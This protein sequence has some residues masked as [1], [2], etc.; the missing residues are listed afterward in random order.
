[1][2][3]MKITNDRFEAAAVKL[4]SKSSNDPVTERTVRMFVDGCR[5]QCTGSFDW[6]YSPPLRFSPLECIT[7][8][9]TS[10]DLAFSRSDTGSGISCKRT[11]ASRLCC[12]DR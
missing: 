9:L 6:R 5:Y 12:R 2:E 11:D 4:L 1:M 3:L 10:S 7:V 8:V